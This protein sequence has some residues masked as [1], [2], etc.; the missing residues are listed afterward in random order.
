MHPGYPDRENMGRASI[1]PAFSIDYYKNL[2]DQASRFCEEFAPN[3][4]KPHG[5]LYNDSALSEVAG[6][7][8]GTDGS[9]APGEMF[10]R[11]ESAWLWEMLLCAQGICG[12]SVPLM[13]L[14]NSGHEQIALAADASFV[15]E[16]FSDRGY[17][18]DGSLIPRGEPGA[19]LESRDDKIRQVLWLADRVDS[20]CVHGDAPDCLETIWLVR[21]T[22]ENNGY[23]VAA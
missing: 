17:N 7:K 23:E 13:G 21:M 12:L 9:N 19:L 3:Y 4:I 2:I 1:K 16:G 8:N 10:S 11:P 14:P 5:A 6:A 15:R 22:L 18:A 20:I